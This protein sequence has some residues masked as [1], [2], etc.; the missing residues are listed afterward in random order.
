[1]RTHG[2]PADSSPAFLP[3]SDYAV[4]GNLHTAALV[5]RSG[6]IDWCCLPHF[7]SPA[8]FCRLLD[9]RIGGFFR[10]GPTRAAETSRRYVE[11]SPVLETS[12]TTAH[13]CARLVDFMPIHDLAESR[14]MA[15][16]E[17]GHRLVRRIEGV[18]GEVDL[19]IEL[20]PSFDFART[21]PRWSQGPEGL[22]AE[23]EGERLLL[24]SSPPLKLEPQGACATASCTVRRGERIDLVLSYSAAGTG[25]DAHDAASA[26][27]LREAT[28]RSWRDWHAQGTYHG[29]YAEQVR[30]SA[31]VLK[32]LTFAPTGAIVAAPTTSLPEEVGGTRNWDYRFCWLRDSAL[33]LRAL[34]SLGFH[35][36]AD[37]FFLWLKRAWEHEDH[38][39]Q[40]M[41]RLDADERL[42]E[43]ELPHL[44][45]YR[46]SRPVRV[47]N[48]A[49]AQ[50]QL[51]IYGYVL[52][53]A[54]LHLEARHEALSPKVRGLLAR[55]AD[56]AAREWRRPDHGLW[57][58][59][60][61]ARQHV[62]SKLMCWVAFDRAVRLAEA[63]YIEGDVHTWRRERDAVRQLI[64]TRG[65]SATR[66]AFTQVLDGDSLD[67]SAL[68]MPMTGFLPPHDPRVVATTEAIRAHLTR[69]GLVYRY[70]NDDG[71]PGTEG[72]F[73]ICSFWLVTNLAM[74]GRVDEARALFE[75]ATSFANDLGLLSEEVDPSSGELLGNHPQ[76]YSHLALIRAA[77]A[78]DE[79]S[80]RG[81]R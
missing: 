20:A 53:A 81:A 30:T 13:G 24:R 57:E 75:H 42:D 12:F 56:T 17:H 38:S 74:Q 72:A 14:L 62:S 35:H 36:A 18:D 63:G 33:V 5:S 64:L 65:F 46:D 70:L 49:A 8:V 43:R 19:R 10:V 79:A 71:M 67:A 55:L 29:A 9:D 22:V 26:E 6:S 50:R 68:Q 47:G 77:L 60:D 40:I 73:I 80:A 27:T 41:Y 44:R 61:Q 76:G 32:L 25:G 39:P 51:D 7:D 16:G 59:R 52:D 21:A 48:G 37:D 4:I 58:T 3:L 23:T 15:Q 66:G 1:M 54:W 45:G 78:I 34:I 2:T 69:R 28:L 11:A 31:L